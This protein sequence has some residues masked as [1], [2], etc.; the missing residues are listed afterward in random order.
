ML[1]WTACQQSGSC[2]LCLQ[3]R[4]GICTSHPSAAIAPGHLITVCGLTIA[5]TSR[6]GSL[7]LPLVPFRL[8]STQWPEGS[9]Q[10][11]SSITSL[12]CQNLPKAPHQVLNR[13]Q[14]PWH[15]LQGHT[16]PSPCLP[17]WFCLCL[18]FPDGVLLH[19]HWSP[20]CSANMPTTGSPS[21]AAPF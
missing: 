8:F 3:N 2:G 15:R 13:I 11:V 4:S 19:R 12:R 18:L 17:L 16:S 14:S 9:C 1:K 6:S 21:D 5:A 7:V 10:T 20:G